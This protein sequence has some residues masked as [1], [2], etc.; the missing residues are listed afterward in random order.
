MIFDEFLVLKFMK[1]VNFILEQLPTLI[2]VI[3]TQ[4]VKD[5]LPLKQL[6][7]AY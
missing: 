2:I 5:N 7:S 6:K 3:L 4:F 1:F